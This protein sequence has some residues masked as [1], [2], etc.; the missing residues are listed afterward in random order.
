MGFGIFLS[1]SF[2]LLL[3]LVF[4][5]AAAGLGFVGIKVIVTYK[6]YEDFLGNAYVMLPAI[7]ILCLAVVM[8]I[9]GVLGCFSAVQESCC[10]LGCFMCLISI[11][12]AAGVVALILGL[13]YKEKIDPELQK[14]MDALFKKFDGKNVE[15]SAVDFIQ[16]ELQCCGVNNYTSWQNT[17]WLQ[18]NG[19]VPLSCCRKNV[20]DCQG[21]LDALD[22]I[23]TEGC[24]AKLQT[25]VHKVL[26]FAMIVILGLALIELLGL[27]SLCVFYRK[28]V[29]VAYQV[30]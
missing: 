11:I 22:K 25:V 9:I 2:I 13:V 7:I 20:T 28:S 12:L 10:G 21:K 30:L 18:V 26:G 24:E 3:S 6:Q 23:Y 15:S 27:I 1:K 19:S 14:N 5:A 8:L 29:S 17:T 4:V 16:E